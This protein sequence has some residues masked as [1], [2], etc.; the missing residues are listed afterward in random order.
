VGTRDDDGFKPPAYI[1]SLIAAINDGAKAAQAGALLVMLVGLYLLATAFSA[2]DE[3]LLLGKAVTISQI[4]AALPVTLSYAIAPAV[5]LFLHVYTL[6]RYD[7]LAANLRHFMMR[8]H[9]DVWSESHRENCLQL[10]AN[11]EFV[12]ALTAPRKCRLYSRLWPWLFCLIMAAFPV[13]IFTIV[14]INALR[15][16]SG[17]IL[18]TQRAWLLLD[19]V[20]LAV[21]FSRNLLDKEINIS[22]RRI[23]RLVWVP[24]GIIL[25]VNIVYLGNVPRDADARVVQ[26]LPMSHKNRSNYEFFKI[27]ALALFRQPLDEVLCPELRW[28]CRYLRVEYR[29]L[30]DTVWD[31]K[32]MAAL[33]KDDVPDLDVPANIQGIVL[34]ERSLRFAVLNYSQLYNVNLSYADLTG[35]HLNGTNFH[36]AQ[37]KHVVLRKASIF[38]A[39]LRSADLEGA[40]LSGAVASYSRLD[41]AYMLE[42]VGNGTIFTGV[43]FVGA[44][45]RRSTWDNA[46]FREVNL[47]GANVGLAKFPNVVMGGHANGANFR[48]AVMA[49]LRLDSVDF[50]GAD[51]RDAQ[52]DWYSASLFHATTANVRF[53]DFRGA[54]IKLDKVILNGSL[55]LF[56]EAP[57]RSIIASESV[58][59]PVEPSFATYKDVLAKYYLLGIA[60]ESQRVASAMVARAQVSYDRL[61]VKGI[62]CDLKRIDKEGRVKL[63]PDVRKE[64]ERVSLDTTCAAQP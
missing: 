18:G 43:S 13:L 32:V 17:I 48:S 51:F 39:N 44:D 28:G 50:S 21:F 36:S 27:M 56:E 26:S 34:R 59:T 54:S 16:Q 25:I 30:V 46:E 58:V 29:T 20:A 31:N 15:Y 49:P 5:F 4:G 41:G 23:F 19:I 6:V 12:L 61:D 52:I 10:L 7:M 60:A 63:W 47:S 38:D 42:V 33:R 2:S 22:A 62:Y 37:M 8:L 9:A 40:D 55:V 35:A 3:D 11:V 1:A 64:V 53:A 14:Q 45:L 57:A 24:I